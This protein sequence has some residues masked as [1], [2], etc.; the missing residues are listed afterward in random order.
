MRDAFI[1]ELDKLASNDP[2]IM[3][4]TGDLGFG[5]LTDYAEKYPDQYINIGVAEQNMLSLIHI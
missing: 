2:S 3:L 1:E 4:L 5:V